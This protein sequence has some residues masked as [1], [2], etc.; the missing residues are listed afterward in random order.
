MKTNFTV[1]L[2]MIF[3]LVLTFSNFAQDYSSEL[4]KIPE[5]NLTIT[6]SVD[7]DSIFANGSLAC[8]QAETN[9]TG[10]NSYWRSFVLSDFGMTDGFS[11]TSVDIG[12][13]Q[14]FAG[15]GGVQPLTCNLF[16]TD[17]TPFPNGF[18]T[19]LTL[20][21]TATMD[22]PDQTV[23]HFSIPVTGVAPGGSELVVDISVPFGIIEKNIFFIGINDFGE[24]A[25]SYILADSCGFSN[26]VP[27]PNGNGIPEQHYVMSVTCDMGVALIEDDNKS[28]M[29]FMLN[30]NYPNPFNPTTTI[31]YQLSENNFVSVKVYDVLGEEIASLVNEKKVA[32][33]YEV[34]FDASNLT[35]GIY[36]YTMQTGSFVETK[37]MVLLR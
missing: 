19:S 11:V 25:P 35:S 29:T 2:T 20:I 1:S 22:V 18:P 26:P 3:T 32:G 24:T 5:H 15:N 37:K 21:G 34:N 10:K 36:F 17:G 13:Q 30:Q 33:S 16:I 31:K 9:F 4:D 23:S 27:P 6:Q 8:R 7:P 14:A 28:S 12:I